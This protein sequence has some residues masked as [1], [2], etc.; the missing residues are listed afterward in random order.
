MLLEGS[1]FSSKA[2]STE[3]EEWKWRQTQKRTEIILDGCPFG[4]FIIKVTQN[5]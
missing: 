4:R 3:E 5:T 1:Y 2:P